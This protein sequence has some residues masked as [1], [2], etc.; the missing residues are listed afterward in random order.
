VYDDTLIGK[1]A[2]GTDAVVITIP[3]V[4]VPMAINHEHERICETVSV[5]AANALMFC[6]MAAPREI[7][8]PI[9][10]GAVDVLSEMRST[11]AGQFVRKQSPSCRWRTALNAFFNKPTNLKPL[12][13]I[14][15]GLF[16]EV[17]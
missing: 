1:G 14:R 11:Q 16:Y 15:E 9:P 2:G 7:P 10:G 5:L 12:P 8:T 13:V 6:D 3:E 4:E 17:K